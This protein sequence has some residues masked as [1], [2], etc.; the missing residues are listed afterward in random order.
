MTL[1]TAQKCL[2]LWSTGEDDV[3]IAA[4]LAVRRLASSTE[5]SVL[6]LVLKVRLALTLIP[7]TLF[8]EI[9]FTEHILGACP[10]VQVYEHV[11]AAIHHTHEKFGMRTVLR[12]PWCN[13][14]ARIRVH[15]STCNTPA[16]G[17]EDKNKGK[18]M[19][20]GN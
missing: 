8:D 14:P 11:P 4:F 6:D 9:N 16:W 1:T 17:Y 3:R 15:T 7:V 10:C 20:M 2:D 12:R 18:R 19:V 13:L 5:G